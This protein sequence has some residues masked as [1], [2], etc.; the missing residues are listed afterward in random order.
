MYH[1]F[2][3]AESIYLHVYICTRI[4]TCEY[5]YVC[6]VVW[7]CVRGFMHGILV[8]RESLEEMAN[9]HIYFMLDNLKILS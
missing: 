1:D 9:I 8:T 5:T 2:Y 3:S 6:T 4:F 7:V